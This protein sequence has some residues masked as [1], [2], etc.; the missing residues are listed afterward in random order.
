MLFQHAK[1][2]QISDIRNFFRLFRHI[3]CWRKFYFEMS[4]HTYSLHF[5]RIDCAKYLCICFFGCIFAENC[6]LCL[7]P[8][9]FC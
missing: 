7:T 4:P 6:N 5:S 9:L 1:V 2:Q 8:L 3:L